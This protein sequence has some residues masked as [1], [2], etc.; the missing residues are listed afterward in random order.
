MAKTLEP[1]AAMI[2]NLLSRRTSTSFP[3]TSPQAK[4]GPGGIEPLEPRIAPATLV[5]LTSTNFL[6]S[7]DSGDPTHLL[8]SVKIKGL[9]AG[10]DIVSIDSRAAN[11]LLYG[12]TKQNTLYT[13]SPYTG[14][15]TKVG[16][17]GPPDL[18]LTGKAL[19]MDFNPTVDRLRVVSD[20][21]QNLRIVPSTGTVVDGD[22]GTMGT[23]PD[24]ALAFDAGDVN[25]GKNPNIAAVAYD[26]NFQ[27]TTQTS[28]FGIDSNLNALVTIGGVNGTPS[29]NGGALFTVGSLGVDPGAMVGFDVAA[30]GTAY[31]SMAVKGK[32]KLFTVDLTTGAATEVGLIGKGSL[33]LDAVTAMPRDEIV[34][35][36]TASNRLVTFHADSPGHLESVVPLR[37]LTAGE[38]V[39]S[40]D[41][42]PAT[43]ELFALTSTNRMLTIDPATGQTHQVGVPLVT[44]PQVTANS[45]G[46]F[47]FNPTV[48]RLRIVNA[49]NDNLRFNPLTFLPVDSDANAANGNTPDTSLAYIATDLNVGVDPN[50]VG[51][52]YDRNDN[53]G[54]T[55]TTLWGIDSVLNNLVRQG[56]VDGN[57]AD[58]AG[59]GSPN[60]GLLTTIGSL[61]VDP[62]DQ[63][64]FDISDRGA[65]GNGVALAVMQLNGETS[66]KLFSINLTAGLTNQPQ[67]GATLIGTVAG[68]EVISAMAIAP[69]GIE[70]GAASYV[71]KEK[72]GAFAV[73]EVKRTG[74]SGSTSS[75]RFGTFDGTALAGV[76]YTEMLNQVIN[77]APGETLKRIQIPILGDKEMDPNETVGLSLSSVAGGS[78]ILGAQGTALLTIK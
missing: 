39:T 61:G 31:A 78:T 64:G 69:S 32:T 47:D 2:S 34:V 16:P 25:A 22:G 77:F 7:F 51:S 29:P 28:L 5:G 13:I 68:G 73:I 17:A 60:G 59:G 37:G 18:A 44:T 70:F 3:Q 74:G 33:K 1:P 23:Q 52:A 27:G 54:A 43:G 36:V 40:I 8:A 38:K 26:R 65:Q 10:E 66:S 12:L 71:V 53:D 55:A 24:T 41:F 6:V 50:I 56:A 49:A 76:D 30:D 21:E 75:V 9:A 4:T 35:A 14:L 19:A 11:G 45:P 58:V 20:L 48:D 63:V 46:G 57:A 62:T 15:A 67:G 42:R 72:A